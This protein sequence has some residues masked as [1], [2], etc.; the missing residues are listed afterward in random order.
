MARRQFMRAKGLREHYLLSLHPQHTA[1][2]RC[3]E[4]NFR[5][6]SRHASLGECMREHR[7][8]R[9]ARARSQ[10]AY[11]KRMRAV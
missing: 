7:Q 1:L 2:G 9:R 8:L 10:W 5:G 11:T 6:N 3:R 4:T